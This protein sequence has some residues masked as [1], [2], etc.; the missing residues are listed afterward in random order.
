MKKSKY[1][2]DTTLCEGELLNGFSMTKE[3]RIKIAACLDNANVLQIEAGIPS[4]G[5]VEKDIICEINS[6]KNNS[7]IS[8]W[9]GMNLSDIKHSLDCNVNIIHISVPVSY[10]QIYTKL[11]KNKAWVIKNLS[12]CVDAA[13]ASGC[14]VT[15]G[16]EDASRADMTFIV[17]LAIMLKDMGVSRI[18]FA[19]SVGIL[20][21]SRTF[22]IIKELIDYSGIEVEFHSHNNLGMA[23]ANSI[24]AA[25]AGADFIDT[26]ISGI[27]LGFGL[28]SFQNFIYVAEPLFNLGVSRME[29]IH[30]ENQVQSI[31]SNDT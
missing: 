26:T 8:V 11:K 13:K 28:C 6:N 31:L 17:S 25:K 9:N 1:I 2:V 15:V 23:I 30:I 12:E 18:R 16:F 19:D 7:K 3:Q 24:Q 14:E 27:G 29:A 20:P 4:K 21:P 5:S 22:K 10:I